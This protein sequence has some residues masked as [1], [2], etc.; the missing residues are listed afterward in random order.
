MDG[1]GQFFGQQSVN[2]PLA[3]E[4]GLTNE[5]G[6]FDDQ[7]KMALA[8]LSRAGMTCVKCRIVSHLE[9]NGLQR[10]G[11]FFAYPISYDAHCTNLQFLNENG[12]TPYF[13]P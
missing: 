10:S 4:A 13:A 1:S 8:A 9:A 3:T 12:S 7:G 6:R 11:Q 5:A 2:L